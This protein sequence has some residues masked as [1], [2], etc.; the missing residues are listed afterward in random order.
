M[1]D[2]TLKR[3]SRCAKRRAGYYGP[4]TRAKRA[5]L[6]LC[7]EALG[8]AALGGGKASRPRG[9]HGGSSASANMSASSCSSSGTT[10]HPNTQADLETSCSPRSAEGD[11]LGAGAPS[12]ADAAGA[13]ER[14]LARCESRQLETQERLREKYNFDFEKGSPLEGER[15]TQHNIEWERTPR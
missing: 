13:V 1:S 4:V 7:Q 11:D 2:A 10:E 14:F 5:K 15:T 9:G 12:R 6:R 3:F 8:V